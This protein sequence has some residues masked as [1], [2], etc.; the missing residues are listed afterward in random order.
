MIYFISY[1]ERM[2]LLKNSVSDDRDEV[3]ISVTNPFGANNLRMNFTLISK[4][5]ITRQMVTNVKVNE[6]DNY[7]LEV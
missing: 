4:Y 7:V 3:T 6:N 2:L 5:P 1:V